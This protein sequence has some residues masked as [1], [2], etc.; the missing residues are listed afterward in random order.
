MKN[1]YIE[2]L[3]NEKVI[4]MDETQCYL[5]MNMDTTIDFQGNKNIEIINSGRNNYRISIILAVSG[6]G[7]KF[8]P[9]IIIKGEEGKTIEKNLNNIYYVKKKKFLY[10][11]HKV[12]VLLKYLNIGIKKFFYIIN[13]LLKKNIYLF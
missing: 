11:N 6:D 8:P 7:H 10:V 13:H 4:N 2:Y 12:G 5:D 9:L 1:N 3:E